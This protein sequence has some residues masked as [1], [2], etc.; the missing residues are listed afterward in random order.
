MP[1]AGLLIKLFSM[2]CLFDEFNLSCIQ[3]MEDSIKFNA[4]FNVSNE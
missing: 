2:C 4:R 1:K 3:L